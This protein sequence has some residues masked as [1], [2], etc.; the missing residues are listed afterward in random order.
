MTPVGIHRQFLLA[1]VLLFLFIRAQL[2]PGVVMHVNFF[3]RPDI[4]H[5]P[6]L[7]ISPDG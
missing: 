7:T 3:N 2:I 5:L 1:D 4:H 6:V